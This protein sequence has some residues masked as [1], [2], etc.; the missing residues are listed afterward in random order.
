MTY[1]GVLLFVVFF[2]LGLVNLI[3]GLFIA[4]H[5]RFCGNCSSLL[6]LVIHWDLLLLCFIHGWV[7]FC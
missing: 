2:C 4:R 6:K 5:L 1:L 3:S 7:I